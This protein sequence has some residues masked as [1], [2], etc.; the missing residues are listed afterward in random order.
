MSIGPHDHAEAVAIFRAMV[1]GPVVQRTFSHGELAAGLREDAT[2]HVVRV[3]SLMFLMKSALVM[4]LSPPRL[5]S[6]N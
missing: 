2:R 5:E 3:K 4:L 6:G 1:I